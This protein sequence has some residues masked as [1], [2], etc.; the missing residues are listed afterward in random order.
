[1]RP[2]KFA[3]PS[4]KSIGLQRARSSGQ[5]A[6]SADQR[7]V[8]S[9]IGLEWTKRDGSDWKNAPLPYFSDC[10]GRGDTV[11]WWP[12]GWR[13]VEGRNLRNAVMAR[14]VLT[15][16]LLLCMFA[17]VPFF[18]FV[19]TTPFFRSPFSRTFFLDGD[20]NTPFTPFLSLPPTSLWLWPPN[21]CFFCT[22]SQFNH[23]V[24]H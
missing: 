12:V 17:V 8:R 21:F 20:G 1:M 16:I 13:R 4:W 2:G 10:R 15:T 11:R 5:F 6:G 14:E 3:A 19:S 24:F 22:F 18:P 9:H 23:S 7:L